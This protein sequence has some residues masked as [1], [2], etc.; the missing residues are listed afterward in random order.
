MKAGP[1]LLLAG[2]GL[3]F[4]LALADQLSSGDLYRRA[5]SLR[6]DR[7]GISVWYEALAKTGVNVERS[8]S[9]LETLQAT[10]AAVILAGV[11]PADLSEKDT[12]EALENLA[13]SGA[14]VTVL[15]DGTLSSTATVK[16][17]NLEIR[18][19]GKSQ[20]EDE[21]SEDAS[22][23][24]QFVASSSWRI[25]RLQSGKP[26]VLERN[27]GAGAMAIAAATQPFLNLSLRENRDVVLLNWALGGKKRAIF[28]ESHLGSA[29]Y[30]TIVGLIRRFR[31]Q[32]MAAALLA[33]SLLFV[34]RSS[35]P[36][37]PVPESAAAGTLSA[38][39]GSSDAL[40]NLLERRVP[41]GK[42]IAACVQEWLKDFSRRIGSQA[43]QE[44]AGIAEER[45]PDAE[46]WERIR[47]IVRGKRTT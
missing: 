30:G 38:G 44:I 10:N 25:V 37:P 14:R 18:S 45:G 36:F 5:S 23:R 9:P 17:W 46:R 7:D 34:W 20:A 21:E 1:L 33:A 39:A 19:A 42:L 4:G 13:K 11:L 35:V 24:Y 8:Y 40:R 32:G 26:V 41:P 15:L 16:A 29:Q 27:F 22:W 43:A 12:V 31:L 2:A 6:T 28:D 47:A 3:C